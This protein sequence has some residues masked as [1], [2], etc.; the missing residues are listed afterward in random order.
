MEEAGGIGNFMKKKLESGENAGTRMAFLD[1]VGIF[2]P[3]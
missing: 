3:I 1:L 2:T